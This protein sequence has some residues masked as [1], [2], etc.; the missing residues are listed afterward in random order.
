MTKNLMK[1]N[2]K[3]RL[4]LLLTACSCLLVGTYAYLYMRWRHLWS[5]EP[6]QTIYKTPHHQDDSL[7][8]V[9]IGDSWADLH[10]WMKMDSFLQ[11]KLEGHINQPVSVVSKG[12]GGEKSRGI[13]QLMFQTEGD[14]T[15]ELFLTGADYCII[16]AGINDAAANM[17]TEQYCAHYRMILDFLITNRIRPIIIEVPD[18]DIMSIHGKKNKKDLLADLLRSFMTHCHMYNYHE[19]REAL[20]KMLQKKQYLD[21]VLFVPMKEWNG[22]SVEINQDLFLSDR[23]HLNKKGYEK[24]DLSIA[25]AIVQDLQTS[26]KSALINKPMDKDTKNRRNYNK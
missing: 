23:I 6:T 18:I 17:G 8:I 16:S 20:F 19:Y 2:R 5:I 11:K 13:Y 25:S 24:L 22:N 26:Q 12:K 14:G 1:M 15:K 10:Y 3:V 4:I 7:R 21:Q 9:M